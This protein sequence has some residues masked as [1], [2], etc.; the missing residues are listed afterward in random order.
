M[1]WG[2]TTAGRMGESAACAEFRV[3]VEPPIFSVHFDTKTA[4]LFVIASSIR[5]FNTHRHR[6]VCCSSRFLP[7][8]SDSRNRCSQDAVFKG[9]EIGKSR[10][11]AFSISVHTHVIQLPRATL[12]LSRNSGL[13]KPP[14]SIF[15]RNQSNGGEE[16]VKGQVIGIDLGR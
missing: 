11:L 8:Q 6:I 10:K 5:I 4:K 14:T 13:R 3:R 7:Q 16:K 15:A 1:H 2:G 12:S 9:S